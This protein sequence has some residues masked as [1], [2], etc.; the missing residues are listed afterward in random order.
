M[1]DTV[2]KYKG[3]TERQLEKY[4]RQVTDPDDWR[5]PINARVAAVDV[6]RVHTAIMFY[7]GT[8]PEVRYDPKWVSEDE[9]D[10][11]PFVI[12]SEGYRNGP[13]GP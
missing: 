8:D 1:T 6:T 12:T 11:T 10:P 5:G 9:L 2:Y 4:F 3:M 7:T 13:C